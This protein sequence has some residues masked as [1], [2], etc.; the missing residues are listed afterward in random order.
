[1][2]KLPD[3]NTI[4]RYLLKDNKELFQKAFVFFE[5]VR[6]GDEKALIFESVFTETIYVLMKFYNVPRKEIS[7]KLREFLLYKG[8]LNDDKEELI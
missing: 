3:T 7:D 8:I 2:K 4:L 1:M 5:N 6:K